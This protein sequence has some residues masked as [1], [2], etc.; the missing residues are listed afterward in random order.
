[1]F[2]LTS[3]SIAALL[4]VTHAPGTSLA[5]WPH[6]GDL[7]NTSDQEA[8]NLPLQLDPK[9]C[10]WVVSLPGPGSS[11]PLIAK[12]RIFVTCEMDSQNGI[13]CLKPDGSESWRRS[14]GTAIAGKHRNASGANPSPVTNGSQIITYYKDT[15]V[16]CYDFDGQPLWQINLA[17]RY[18]A[19]KLWWDLG[20]SPAI[21]STGVVF[22]VMHEGESYLVTLDIHTGAEIWRTLRN[23]TCA[24][25][26]DQSYTTPTI[27]QCDQVETIVSFGANHLTA[28]HAQTGKL[29]WECGGF[30][31]NDEGLWRTISSAVAGHGIAVT[32]YGRGEYVCG[33]RLTGHGDI[34]SSNRIW[35]R[36]GIGSDVPTPSIRGQRVTLLSDRGEVHCLD[37]QTGTS[38]WQD[39]LPKSGKK[40]YSSPLVVG[41]RLYCFR[42][43]GAAFVCEID[44]GLKVLSENNLDEQVIATPVLLGNDLLVRSRERLFR[45]AK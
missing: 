29:I 2:R 10:A 24:E 37:L 31:P 5:A 18:G 9:Q 36:E 12:G 25:E 16:A 23:Y 28:H 8:D 41:N 39:Q 11:T 17:D 3:C 15:S 26:S 27:V 44:N 14:F 4:V 35:T 6:L 33:V 13:V 7:P 22:A 42:E 20:A 32:S 38:H 40:Y 43:D 45:F 21:T 34:T 30:N 1:M 19:G